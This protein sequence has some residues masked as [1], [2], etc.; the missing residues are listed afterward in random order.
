VVGL[1]DAPLIAS[2]VEG[3]VFV[4]ETNATPKNAVRVALQRLIG[5][6][7]AVIGVALTKFE[8]KS[9]L[10]NYGYGY[11]YGYGEATAKG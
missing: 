7:A 3:A 11:G 6:N 1:A 4:I 2:K 8:A 5:A 9:G 10:A